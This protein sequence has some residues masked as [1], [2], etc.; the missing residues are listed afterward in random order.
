MK[1]SEAFEQKPREQ[2]DARTGEVI[3][4]CVGRQ[5]WWFYRTQR[6][7]ECKHCGAIRLVQR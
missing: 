5:H 1:V 7:Q 3:K 4:P 6:L 2:R